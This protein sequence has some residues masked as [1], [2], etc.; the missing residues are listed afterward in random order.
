MSVVA[1]YYLKSSSVVA[2]VPSGGFQTAP[3]RCCLCCQV[4][5]KDD[6]D[7]GKEDY[8]YKKEAEEYEKE[9]KKPEPKVVEKVVE[10][11]VYKVCLVLLWK[12]QLHRMQFIDYL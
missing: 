9:Y 12:Q 6:Y 4:Y 8:E 10:K 1:H 2:D 3:V 5:R 7:Y 11:I